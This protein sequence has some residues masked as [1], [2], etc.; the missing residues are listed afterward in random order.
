MHSR[1]LPLYLKIRFLNTWN[2]SSFKQPGYYHLRPLKLQEEYIFFRLEILI[3]FIF[4][5]SAWGL[6]CQ[7]WSLQ[8]EP[9]YIVVG[10]LSMS[11]WVIQNHKIRFGSYPVSL[12]TALHNCISNIWLLAIII[13]Q[14]DVMEAVALDIGGAM[15]IHLI[16]KF[17]PCFWKL[18][19]GSYSLAYRWKLPTS[20]AVPPTLQQSLLFFLT[21][22]TFFRIF[23][24]YFN[25]SVSSCFLLLQCLYAFCFLTNS[26]RQ[27]KATVKIHL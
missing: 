25:Y 9:N 1:N 15:Q 13:H 24:L 18:T 14:N 20:A 22:P 6:I 21:L 3:C 17:L 4:L 8:G 23:Y 27:C 16:T 19:L 26:G 7:S 12:T 5:V 2:V 10:L 11:S